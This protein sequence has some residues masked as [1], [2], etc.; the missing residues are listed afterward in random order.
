MADGKVLF[1]DD[2]DEATPS[3]RSDGLWSAAAP[4]SVGSRR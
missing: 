3:D 2:D 1:V 4:V